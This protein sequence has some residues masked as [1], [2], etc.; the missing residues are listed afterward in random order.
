[1]VCQTSASGFDTVKTTG[2]NLPD[3]LLT[4]ANNPYDLPNGNGGKDQLNISLKYPEGTDAE[5]KEQLIFVSSN[6]DIIS[7][8]ETGKLTTNK[9][10]D[11]V[12]TIT[13]IARASGAS[14]EFYFRVT[15]DQNVKVSSIE[16]TGKNEVDID[17]TIQLTANVKPVNAVNKEV[18]WQV[19]TGAQYISVDEKGNVTGLK[20]G[21]ATVIAVSGENSAVKSSEF[22][23]TVHSPAKSI[24]ILDSAITIEAEKTYTITKT[25]NTSA[26]N[27]YVIE[28]A[29]TDDAIEWKSSN[30]NV[31]TV[32][33]TGNNVVLKAIA[34]GTAKLKAT[35]T[36]GVSKEV[37]VT[38][39]PKKIAV[40]SISITN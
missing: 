1:M 23:I 9:A 5:S 40:A 32:T 39:E 12:V 7:V 14:K 10:S 36:S 24:Q 3:N 18:E 11:E 27:G 4:S 26:K 31:L 22:K 15:D 34:E 38:V 6:P 19:K 2:D 25:N 17:G 35:A 29:D 21:T 8:D 20:K 30:E 16:V 13:V 33:V 37:T 28:P